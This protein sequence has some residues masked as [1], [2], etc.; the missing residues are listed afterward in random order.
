MTSKWGWV[1]IQLGKVQASDRV[2]EA[3]VKLL[4]TLDDEVEERGLSDDE[5]SEVLEYVKK[6]SLGYAL[7]KDAPDEKWE[8]VVPGAYNIGDTVRVREDAYKGTHGQRHNGKRGRIVAVHQSKT[9]VLYD[10]ARN[11]EEQFYHEPP[12]LQRLV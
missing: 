9:V 12:N 5:K 4:K 10:D 7:V 2:R 11:S 1:S 6:L 8:D 3:T